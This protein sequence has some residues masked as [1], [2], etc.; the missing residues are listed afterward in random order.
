MSDETLR[1]LISNLPAILTAAAVLFGAITAVLFRKVSNVATDVQK[2][3]TIV[4]A[5]NTALVAEI[6]ELNDRIA[7]LT[8]DNATL[9]EAARVKGETP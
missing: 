5:N 9:T 6:K 3:H 1:T 2:V 8:G 4:N 7:L